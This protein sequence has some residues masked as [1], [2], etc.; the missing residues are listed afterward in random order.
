MI[1]K[2]TLT[3]AIAATLCLTLAGEAHAAPAGQSTAQSPTDS[4]DSFVP[5]AQDVD[6]PVPTNTFEGEQYGPGISEEVTE[7]LRKTLDTGL[8][9][10]GRAALPDDAASLRYLDNGEILV[11]DSEGEKVDEITNDGQPL[12]QARGVIPQEAK[13]IIE[14][15]LGL[16]VFSGGLAEELARQVSSVQ[17]AIKFIIRRIGFG[18]AVGCVGGI[19]W[20]YV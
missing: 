3:T 14:A 17:T 18:A 20:H 2:K 19:I 13:D 15:C 16:G 10:S 8:T 9:N 5:C 4:T 7:E 1:R 12:I 11:L 6:S